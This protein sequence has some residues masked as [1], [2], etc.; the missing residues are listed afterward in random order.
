[1]YFGNPE[2]PGVHGGER[3]VRLPALQP[4]MRGALGGPLES[5][6]DIT[7]VKLLSQYSGALRE[8]S[9]I[10]RRLPMRREPELSRQQTT[11][12]YQLL[13]E[14]VQD[15]AIFLIDREG[16]VTSW[17][18]GAERVLGWTEAEILGQPASRLFTPDDVVDGVPLQELAKAAADGR[19]E[20]DRWH[21][22]KDGSR[23]WA[24]GT[25]TAVRNDG[26][27]L[28]GFG[29]IL[30]DR[31]VQKQLEE[32]LRASLQEKEVLLKEIYHRVKNNLQVISS[33]LSLQAEMLQDREVLL[34]FQDCQARIQSMAL[35]HEVLYQSSNLAQVN[36]G[37]YAR[38][39]A[40]DLLRAQS[41]APERIRLIVETDEV[42][43]S[44]EKAV[45]CGLIL[46]ELLTNCVKHAFPAGRAGDIRIV[47][48]A[49]AEAQVTISVSDTGV[50]FPEGLDF[51]NA[52]SLGMQLA[53]L[54]TEQLGGTIDLE[55]AEGTAFT[56]RFSVF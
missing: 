11:E 8:A 33:L 23:F 31:T 50:G 24:S 15:Y 27:A 20:D 51:R 16:R 21:I 4:A 44:A 12:W 45:P 22:R 19:A 56:I 41:V 49:D 3:A 38:R 34:A 53:C 2:D 14:D 30:R 46:N 43:L 25:L 1:V 48:R 55:R 26:G 5:T 47:L 9:D 37:D 17:N 35:V 18:A 52:A 42:W 29:K 36:F 32:Q 39:L 6:G 54:L 28:I 7:P 13:I 10:T 40:A